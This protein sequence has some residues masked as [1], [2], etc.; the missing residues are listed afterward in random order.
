MPVPPRLERSDVSVR[1]FFE[2]PLAE[3]GHDI[4]FKAGDIVEALAKPPLRGSLRLL[5]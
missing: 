2:L 3:V 5:R 4:S 1:E